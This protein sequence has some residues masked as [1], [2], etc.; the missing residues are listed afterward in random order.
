MRN[1]K[2]YVYFHFVNSKS[3]GFI[4]GKGMMAKG[5]KKGGA[6]AHQQPT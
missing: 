4:S 1:E 2:K 6:F 5:R 3:L